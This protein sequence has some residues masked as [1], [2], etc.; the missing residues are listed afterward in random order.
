MIGMARAPE[1]NQIVLTVWRLAWRKDRAVAKLARGAICNLR[2]LSWWTLRN[3]EC[4]L[5]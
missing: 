4:G 5:P 1:T 3:P 2:S